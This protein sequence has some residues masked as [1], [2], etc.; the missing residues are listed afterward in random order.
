MP[1][2]PHPAFRPAARGGRNDVVVKA[3]LLQQQQRYVHA[4]PAFSAGASG[5]RQRI[6]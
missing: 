2:G 3:L 6:P 5:P 4:R 1:P